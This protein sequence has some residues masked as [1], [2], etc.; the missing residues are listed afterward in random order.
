M[1]P[2]FGYPQQAENALM[3]Y[4]DKDDLLF[5]IRSTLFKSCWD[6]GSVDLNP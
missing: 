4:D 1:G 6:N 2:N 5:Y 3:A